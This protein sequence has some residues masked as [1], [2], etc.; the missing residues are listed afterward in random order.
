MIP[1]QV[2]SRLGLEA[3]SE[4][5]LEELGDRVELRVVGREVRIEEAA[6][7]LPV[8]R[9]QSDVPALTDED[10]RLLIEQQRR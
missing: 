5:E 8:A 1:K 3:G 10:V 9:A 7:G 2:R 6:D 4:L